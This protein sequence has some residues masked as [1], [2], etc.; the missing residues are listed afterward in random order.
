MIYSTNTKKKL[1]QL[2]KDTPQLIVFVGKPGS[3]KLQIMKD[4]SSS[5]T[6]PANITVIEPVDG[7]K[8]IGIEQIRDI[9][10]I[11][12][13]TKKEPQVIMVPNAE[14]ITNEAQNSMLKLLE[15]TPANLHI[16]LGTTS[17]GKLLITIRS[18]A[19]LWR[20]MNPTIEEVI[21]EYK[22]LDINKIEQ[23]VKLTSQRS[24]YLEEYLVEGKTPLNIDTAKEILSEDK[25]ERLQRVNGLS[26]DLQQS[27]DIIESILL[28]SKAAAEIAIKNNDLQK[29]MP[30]KNRLALCL[31]SLDL[32]DKSVQPKLVLTRLFMVL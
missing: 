10:K 14:K 23:A 1:S 27:V 31:E 15:D 24:R 2:S 30:W 12:F 26:K 22:N 32:L 5:I 8:T 16:F 25:F 4:L 13:L 18:R 29:M 28:I 21:N 19:Y 17:L 20:V 6:S 7:K 3:G 9:K 11:S